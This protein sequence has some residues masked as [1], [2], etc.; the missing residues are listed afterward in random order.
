[1]LEQY[2]EADRIASGRKPLGFKLWLIQIFFP[3]HIWKFQVLLRK[4]EYYNN[5]SGGIVKRLVYLYYKFR[6]KKISFR[7]GFS[8][9]EN[10]FGPGLSI[11]HYGTIVVNA[12][13][14]IGANCRI[15]VGT[16]IGTSGGT[17]KAPA[18]GD[19]VY[20]APGVKI[21]GDVRIASNTAIAANAVVNKSFQEEGNILAGMPAKVVGPV[22]I[23]KL[24]KH[25]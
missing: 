23:K 11:P 14:K 18:L 10:V 4:C 5:T 17:D 2:I 12:K 3:D 25:I 13:S 9:P 6:L 20:I 24:I 15:H 22:D 21:Y 7:L 1:M 8:I 19:N 16:N